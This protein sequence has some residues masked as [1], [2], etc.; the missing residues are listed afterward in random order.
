MLRCI[1]CQGLMCLFKTDC[2]MHVHRFR[3]KSNFTR[4]KP[5][6]PLSII[7]EKHPQNCPHQTGP[8]SGR[9]SGC[10][11]NHYFHTVCSPMNLHDGARLVC[12]KIRVTTVKQ[13]TNSI[14]LQWLWFMGNIHMVNYMFLSS[15]INY[16]AALV[17][18]YIK[19]QAFHL[20]WQLYGKENISLTATHFPMW[21]CPTQQ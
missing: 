3:R 18:L 12:P 20:S 17:S 16:G 11:F 4:K 21:L 5:C 19:I 14:K 10:I 7:M 15:L 8:P 1:L 6:H 13:K 9:A 2:V